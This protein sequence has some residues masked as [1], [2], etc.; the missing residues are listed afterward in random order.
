MKRLTAFFVLFL[1]ALCFALTASAADNVVHRVS[2]HGNA[3]YVSLTAQSDC[4]LWGAVY[5]ES[6]KMIDAKSANVKA[7]EDEQ[8]WYL[9]FM[10]TIPENAYAKAFLLDRETF[11]PLCVAADTLNDMETV[12]TQ[13]VYAILYADGTLVFQHGNAPDPGRALERICKVDMTGTEKYGWLPNALSTPWYDVRFSIK[14]V[15]FAAKIQPKSTAY[16]FYGCSNL[17]DIK[18]LRNLDTANVTDM[19]RMF[20]LCASLTTLDVGGFD[21]SNVT[22]MECMFGNC[23]FLTS[24]DVSGFNTANVTNMSAMFLGCSLLETLDV[25]NFNTANVTD[26][27]LMF[28]SCT[29]LRELNLRNFNTAKVTNMGQMFSDCNGLTALDL[30]G[31]NT[32]NVTNMQAMFAGCRLAGLDLSSFNTANVTDMNDMFYDCPNLIGIYVSKSFVTSQVKEGNCMFKGCHL[33][34][35]GSGTTYNAEHDDYIYARIDGGPDNPGYFTA[36]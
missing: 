30:R 15:E 28:S 8:T 13:D 5:D 24:L 3:V 2:I 1:T 4:A 17:T 20:G 34:T 21:T 19:E 33:L 27:Q 16:W 35:G 36:K 31:F 9:D 12:Y 29:S 23:L 22:N 6:G 7:R 32:A 18:N 25:S 11:Q 10:N 26:M 14:Q